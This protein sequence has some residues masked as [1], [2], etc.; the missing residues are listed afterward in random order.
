MNNIQRIRLVSETKTYRYVKVETFF[1]FYQ[2]FNQN[3]LSMIHW[4]IFLFWE[5]WQWKGNWAKGMHNDKKAS[6]DIFP[7]N[8]CAIL[9]EKY[10]GIDKTNDFIE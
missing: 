7:L 9:T 1:Q 3:I 5:F 8:T 10:D 6:F 2:I 4:E